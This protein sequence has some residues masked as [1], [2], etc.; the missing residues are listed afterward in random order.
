MSAIA[1]LIDETD[2]IIRSDGIKMIAADRAVVAVVDFFLSKNAFT[3]YN[4]EKDLRIGINLANFLRILRRAMPNDIMKMRIV[5]NKFEIKLIGE[6]QR[7]FTLPMI[8]VSKEE[9]PPIDK[10]EFHTSFEIV[11]EILSSGIDDADLI[12]DSIV[13]NVN[14]D[15]VSLRA[16]SDS[17]SAELELV[18]GNILRNLNSNESTRSRYSLD[19]LKKIIKA[20]RL[21]D[22]I[23]INL[24]TDYPMK[25]MFNVP[26]RMQLNFILAPRVEE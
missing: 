22:T 5:N 20:K 9:I 14:K 1:E 2:L 15:G 10:L 12:T 18:P 23:K 26:E 3:E 4:Y 16:E 24:S 21:S 7:S 11:S 17:S 8:D 19:Y 25:I 6:S 13:F